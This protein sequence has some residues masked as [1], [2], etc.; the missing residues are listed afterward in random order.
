MVTVNIG[1]NSCQVS[2]VLL[3]PRPCRLATRIVEV[4][5]LV[6]VALSGLWLSLSSFSFFEMVLSI[7]SP[8]VFVGVVVEVVVFV[9][10][11]VVVEVLVVVS[12]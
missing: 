3:S 2:G 4:G 5:S 11:V 8:V 7:V 9:V 12:L 10:V 6:P 1:N